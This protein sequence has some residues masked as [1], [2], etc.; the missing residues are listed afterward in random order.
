MDR[1]Q[2]EHMGQR[3]SAALPMNQATADLTL[4]DRQRRERAYYDEYARRTAPEGLSFRAVVGDE[5][6]PWNAYWRVAGIVRD[7]RTAGS[8]RLLDFG[9]GPGNYSVMF[10]KLGYE[11]FGFDISPVN[12]ESA[13]RLARKYKV[14][15][16]THFVQGVAEHLAYP[17]GYFD[18]IVGIDI[19]H[20]VDIPAA[21]L[22]MLRVLKP[23]GT[24]IFKEPVE[25]PLFDRLRNTRFGRWVAPKA[26]SFERHITEDERKL[27]RDDLA[28]VRAAVPSLSVHHFR[29]LARLDALLGNRFQWKGSSIFEMVDSALLRYLPIIDR[30]AGEAVL[31]IRR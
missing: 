11:V 8:Q 7:L 3:G 31:V 28:T 17:D 12:V 18:V 27:S 10:A 19:L 20:H 30:V 1:R 14:A 6:R 25:A 22:E 23:G 5:R 21:M 24:A 9:C 26:A 2:G 13:E 4:T 15:D 16:R 29:V